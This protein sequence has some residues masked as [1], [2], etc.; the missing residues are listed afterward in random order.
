MPHVYDKDFKYVTAKDSDVSNDYL[1]KKFKKIAAELKAQQ[2]EASK[3][4]PKS[5]VLRLRR[6]A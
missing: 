5:S 1:R 2:A 3:Q 6:Q 4:K